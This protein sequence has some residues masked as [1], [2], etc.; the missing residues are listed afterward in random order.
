MTVYENRQTKANSG[1]RSGF[2]VEMIPADVKAVFTLRSPVLNAERTRITQ[3]AAK[4]RLPVTYDIY[5]EAQQICSKSGSAIGWPAV[6][7][8]ADRVLR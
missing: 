8:R 1:P 4:T 5:V 6:S 7:A 3:M 2:K